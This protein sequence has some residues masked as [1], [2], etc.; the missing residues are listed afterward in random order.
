MCQWNSGGKRHSQKM[1]IL[2]AP[3]HGNRYSITE[4]H[5]KSKDFFALCLY[6]LTTP[7]QYSC[8]S[9]SFFFRSRNASGTKYSTTEYSM[10]IL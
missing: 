4:R 10:V 9:G 8:T 6:F 7:P 1:G 3:Y 2:P 5:I